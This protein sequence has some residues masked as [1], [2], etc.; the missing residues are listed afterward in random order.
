MKKARY[1]I[2]LGFFVPIIGIGL[3]AA[4]IM[5][6]S[7]NLGIFLSYFLRL[8]SLVVFTWGCVELAKA[9]GYHP[10]WGV[11]GLGLLWGLLALIL[12]PTKKKIR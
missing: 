9:K 1:L 2:L 11:L 7:M 8:T 12:L 3:I 10:M 4:F 5:P 6:I